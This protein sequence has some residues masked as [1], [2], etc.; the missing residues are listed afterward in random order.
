MVE[1]IGFVIPAVIY[2]GLLA[3]VI[4]VG[5]WSFVPLCGELKRQAVGA[6]LSAR[7]PPSRLPCSSSSWYT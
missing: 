1:F 4:A 5:I 7:S 3:A 2:L 6:L